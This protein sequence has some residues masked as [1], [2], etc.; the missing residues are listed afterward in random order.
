[1]FVV[2]VVLSSRSGDDN[3]QIVDR[4]SER[5]REREVEASPLN[6]QFVAI[7]NTALSTTERERE[8]QKVRDRK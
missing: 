5:E 7:L 2:V 1:M 8:R 4:L 6:G 3:L